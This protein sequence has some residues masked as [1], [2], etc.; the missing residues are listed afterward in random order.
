M[1]EGDIAAHDICVGY[2]LHGT[3]LAAATIGRDVEAR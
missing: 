1:N 2:P 3:T